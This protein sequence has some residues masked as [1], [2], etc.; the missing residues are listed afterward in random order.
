MEEERNNYRL[1]T[2]VP[3]YTCR[4]IIFRKMIRHTKHRYIPLESLTITIKQT[5]A[6]YIHAAK[7]S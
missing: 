5:I 4:A 6:H 2:E 1:K 3:I 7:F